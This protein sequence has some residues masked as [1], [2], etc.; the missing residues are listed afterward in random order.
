VI[1][2]LLDGV[3]GWSQRRWQDRIAPTAPVGLRNVTRI[4]AGGYQVL[5]L[6]G[7][8][9][10]DSQLRIALDNLW[11]ARQIGPPLL[12]VKPRPGSRSR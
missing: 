3:E 11:R 5:A 12:A 8:Q 9:A 1:A 4:A 6:V 2:A 7:A 10:P